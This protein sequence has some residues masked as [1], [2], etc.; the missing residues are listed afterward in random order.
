MSVSQAGLREERSDD[1][2]RAILKAAREVFIETGFDGA[3]VAEIGRRAGIA[4]GT[5]YLYYKT[6]SALMEAVLSGFWADLTRGARDVVALHAAPLDRLRALADYHLAG[7]LRDMTFL[8]L[9]AKLRKAY[10]V[11][12]ETRDRLKDYVAVFD[13]IFREAVESGVFETQ[14]PVWIARD[15][16]YGALEYSARTIALHEAPRPTGVVDNLICA[17]KAS[18]GASDAPAANEALVERLERAVAAL[19]TAKPSKR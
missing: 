16:F 10:S 3:R 17:F 7:L 9:A 1:R 12:P 6:K 19:E 14:T 11:D 8:D 4:E 2:R 13:G 18:Y 5:V 15:M